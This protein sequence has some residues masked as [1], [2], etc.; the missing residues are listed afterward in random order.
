MDLG[1]THQSRVKLW[2]SNTLFGSIIW[3]FIEKMPPVGG[4]TYVKHVQYYHKLYCKSLLTY[5]QFRCSDSCTMSCKHRQKITIRTRRWTKKAPRRRGKKRNIRE[6]T[7]KRRK[8]RRT[9]KIRNEK[10]K[11][12]EEEEEE[13]P[14]STP[15][16]KCVLGPSSADSAKSHQG[17]FS[18]VQKANGI[19]GTFD[20]M[21]HLPQMLSTFCWTRQQ[22]GMPI[23]FDDIWAF[24]TSILFWSGLWKHVFG[25][26]KCISKMCERLHACVVMAG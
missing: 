8:I 20:W 23:Y 3:V 9:K 13:D 16:R 2:S 11:I 1:Y 18:R 21:L 22:Q 4:T 19:A 12:Q 25:T 17:F 10:K 7:K 5:I 24:A 14:F 15:C 6:K 26:A